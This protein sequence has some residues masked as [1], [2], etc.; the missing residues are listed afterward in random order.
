MYILLIKV[1]TINNNNKTNNRKSLLISPC[2]SI[3]SFI[4]EKGSNSIS[5]ADLLK[6]AEN[7]DRYLM[8]TIT[9]KT[10]NF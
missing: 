10:D 6:A 9:T 2:W 8:F 4:C 3:A 5:N 7:N 1:R